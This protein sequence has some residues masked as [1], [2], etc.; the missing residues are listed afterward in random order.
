[1]EQV[2]KGYTIT[3]VAGLERIEIDQ[4]KGSV[5]TT[6]VGDGF[7]LTLDL[8]GLRDFAAGIEAAVIRA[9]GIVDFNGAS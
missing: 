3:D 4:H 2:I 9:G 1:M 8:E 5:E 6:L 7:A